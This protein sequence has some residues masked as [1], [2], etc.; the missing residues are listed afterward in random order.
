MILYKQFYLFFS[1]SDFPT[2]R[3]KITPYLIITSLTLLRTVKLWLWLITDRS[4]PT[5]TLLPK[6]HLM[7]YNFPCHWKGSCSTIQMWL[8]MIPGWLPQQVCVLDVLWCQ[9][10]KLIQIVSTS[11]FHEYW[12]NDVDFI[13]FI[14]SIFCRASEASNIDSFKN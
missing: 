10:I 11:E 3:T 6:S 5:C 13:F 2:A 1:F 4:C 12:W 14:P 8:G 9:P 7:K